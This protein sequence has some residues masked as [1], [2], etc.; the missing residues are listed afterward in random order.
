M[1]SQCEEKCPQE[2]VKTI[3]E[4]SGQMRNTALTTNCKDSWW[5]G[6]NNA[7]SDDD[8]SALN[9]TETYSPLPANEM[10]FDETQLYS[11]ALTEVKVEKTIDTKN[12]QENAE[13]DHFMNTVSHTSKYIRLREVNVNGRLSVKTPSKKRFK[14]SYRTRAPYD[15]EPVEEGGDCVSQVSVRISPKPFT[16]V[17]HQDAISQ[18]TFIGKHI[19]FKQGK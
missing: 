7:N 16:I 19:T 2:C 9:D 18:E 11:K 10:Q 4:V 8:S 12:E 13:M 1:R 3:F 6:R 14:R 15:A 5:K 17:K